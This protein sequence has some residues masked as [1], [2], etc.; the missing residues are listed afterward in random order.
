MSGEGKSLLRVAVRDA[1]LLA[2]LSLLGPYPTPPLPYAYPSYLLALLS[3]LGQSVDHVTEGGE[4]LVDVG[5][6]LVRDRVARVRV[7]VR[8]R[9]RAT[10]RVRCWR[11]P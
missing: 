8:V 2:L 3:L 7:G 9:V 6:L 10:A 5:A 1:Y 11:P 4:A